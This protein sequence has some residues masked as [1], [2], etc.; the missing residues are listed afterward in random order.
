MLTVI[1]TTYGN[2]PYLNRCIDYW[3]RSPFK[4]IIADG[5]LHAW[6]GEIPSNI[7]YLHLPTPH[8]ANP[9]SDYAERKLTA[10][11]NV[12]TKYAANCADDDF[13]AFN[14]LKRCV[15]YLETNQEIAATHG[16]GPWFLHD[17]FNL[18]WRFP[19]F[20]KKPNE[21]AMAEKADLRMT[22]IL[23]PFAGIIYGVFRT[24]VLRDA[25]KLSENLTSELMIE[26]SVSLS[27]VIF[28]KFISVPYFY[29]A[30][31][32]VPASKTKHRRRVDRYMKDTANKKIIEEWLISLA[33]YLVKH[34]HDVNLE[35]A[36]RQIESTLGV[37]ISRLNKI[38]RQNFINN[39]PGHLKHA[40]RF[41]V[42]RPILR[43]RNTSEN[44]QNSYSEYPL[45][46]DSQPHN[47]D[48][49]AFIEARADFEQILL[50]INKFGPLSVTS[51]N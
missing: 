23:D 41:F 45:T 48:Q 25:F 33:E 38:G 44:P 46:V 36:R 14:G 40:V 19:N 42:P 51:K 35:Q 7:T 16:W 15:Q 8:S 17:E 27:A 5:S 34:S 18:R 3:S 49:Q 29:Q 11:E 39:I 2:R 31:E 30:R 21:Q 24:P 47:G 28:G 4:I 32:I 13:L 26:L 43:A 12:K 6:D 1:I 50:C 10:I 20:S 37:Y 9:F 22:Q